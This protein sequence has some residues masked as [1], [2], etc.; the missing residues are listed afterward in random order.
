MGTEFRMY[1]NGLNPKKTNNT[2][3][4]RNQLGV[5]YYESNLMQN[6]GPRRMKILLP[7]VSAS[8]NI[9]KQFM[10]LAP[11]QG[12]QWDHANGNNEFIDMLVNKT[13]KWNTS[14]NAYVLN[15]YG[16]VDKPSVKNF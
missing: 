12:I 2:M 9:A 13:P 3:E 6:K 7:K 14:I 10:P 8:T 5:V 4:I 11:N 1:D 16:R 15:F